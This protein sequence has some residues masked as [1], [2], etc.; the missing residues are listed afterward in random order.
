MSNFSTSDILFKALDGQINID[1]AQGIVECFVA[2]IGNK[3]SVGDVI[4]SGAFTESLKRRKP[5][6]VW[7]HNWN[8][9]IG[10]VL[11]IYEVPA[12]DPRIPMKMKMAG[13]GG[14]YARVQFNLATE[15][16][17]E[18]FGSVA[19]FGQ[20][21]EW[22]IG[23]K[24][25]QAT[26][27]PTMQA[28]VLREV[29]LY[30]VSPVLHGANQLT[31]TLSVKSDENGEKCGPEGM[32]GG[33]RQSRPGSTAIDIPRFNLSPAK[34]QTFPAAN[35]RTDIFASGESGQLGGEARAALEMELSSRSASPLKVVN[36]TENSVV[37]DRTMPDGTRMT[38]RIGYH[39]ESQSGRYMFGKPEKMASQQI[40]PSQMPS[41]PMMVKPGYVTQSYGDSQQPVSMMKSF[42]DQLD[43]A[44]EVLS[45]AGEDETI[46]ESELQKI[47][48]A[49]DYL[50]NLAGGQQKKTALEY[51]VWCK[52][53]YAYEVKSLLDPVLN[54]HRLEAHV[55]DYGVHITSGIN[56]DSLQAL[57]SAH[58]NISSYLDGGGGSKK[59]DGAPNTKDAPKTRIKAL[60][61]KIGPKLGGGLRAAPAGMAFVD[62]TGV[63]DADSDGIV[64]EGKPGLERPIIPRFIVPKNLARKLSAVVEGDAEAIEKQRRSGNGNVSFDEKKLR[65]IIDDIGGDPNLLRSL[66]GTN[67]GGMRSRGEMRPIGS[68]LPF[69]LQTGKPRKRFDETDEEFAK[70][71]RPLAL[72]LRQTKPSKGRQQGMRSRSGDPEIDY[73]LDEQDDRQFRENRLDAPRKKPQKSMRELREE[74]RLKRQRDAAEYDTEAMLDEWADD[75][76]NMEREDRGMRSRG[77]LGPPDSWYEPD[78]DPVEPLEELVGEEWNR[79]DS[80][81]Y[82]EAARDWTR[83]NVDKYKGMTDDEWDSIMDD[84]NASDDP[85]A[86]MHKLFKEYDNSDAFGD[87][88]RSAAQ[89]D[90][91]EGVVGGGGRGFRSRSGDPEID[92]QLDEQDDRQFRDNRLDAPRKKPQKSM[93]ELREEN[94]LKRQREAEN[95]PEYIQYMLDE[96][97]DMQRDM[98]R[99]DRGMRSTSQRKIYSDQVAA[100]RARK[101][102]ED[103]GV[104]PRDLFQGD[105]ESTQDYLDRITP[106]IEKYAPEI[107]DGRS[108][109]EFVSKDNI[110]EVNKLIDNAYSNNDVIR[111]GLD[112]RV[113]N[114]GMGDA[115]ESRLWMDFVDTEVDIADGPA[116]SFLQDSGLVDYIETEGDSDGDWSWSIDV[117]KASPEDKKRFVA[118]A[119]SDAIMSHEGSWGRDGF[120]LRDR[121]RGMRSRRGPTY[122]E[123]FED[124]DQDSD[125]FENLLE[126]TVE[127]MIED[128]E[129]D[130]KDVDWS[131]ILDNEKVMRRAEE[132]WNSDVETHWGD[133]G[134]RQRDDGMRSRL[135]DAVRKQGREISKD[136]KREAKKFAR[137]KGRELLDDAVD[138]IFDRN[139]RDRGMRSRRFRED[140]KPDKKLKP[141][142][143]R[144]GPV[145]ALQNM[146]DEELIKLL[147]SYGE[148]AW[149]PWDRNPQSSSL[150]L[151][152]RPSLSSLVQEL[153]SRGYDVYQSEGREPEYFGDYSAGDKSVYAR[154]RGQEPSTLPNGGMSSGEEEKG[155]QDVIDSQLEDRRR[156]ESKTWKATVPDDYKP[157]DGALETL[158]PAER[159]L[160]ETFKPKSKAQRKQEMLDSFRNQA[161][162]DVDSNKPY[163]TWDWYPT[164]E[165]WDQEYKKKLR[166]YRKAQ[167]KAYAHDL[168]KGNVKPVEERA[169]QQT[170][171]S[172]ENL[173]WDNFKP[174]PLR[175]GPYDGP[176]DVPELLRGF[177]SKITDG[178]RNERDNSVKSKTTIEQRAFDILAQM[179]QRSGQKFGLSDKELQDIFD[180]DQKINPELMKI[181]RSEL[182]RQGFTKD[183]VADVL[184]GRYAGY[185]R[186]QISGPSDDGER[187]FESEMESIANRA[188]LESMD[189][190]SDGLTVDE[191]QDFVSSGRIPQGK[192]SIL[193]RA[194]EVYDNIV[195]DSDKQRTMGL[196]SRTGRNIDAE[197]DT[198]IKKQRDLEKELDDEK[199][200][201]A[202]FRRRQAPL[203]QEFSDLRKEQG[204]ESATRKAPELDATGRPRR[205]MIERDEKGKVKFDSEK[206]LAEQNDKRRLTMSELGFTEDEINTLM[207]ASS[208]GMRSRSGSHENFKN[209]RD[210]YLSKN[211]EGIVN[212]LEELTQRRNELDA[213]SKE[214]MDQYYANGR[215]FNDEE[216]D[217]FDEI[218][219]E[220]DS[221]N[222]EIKGI[223]DWAK[224]AVSEDTQRL[225]GRTGTTKARVA[226]KKM[227]D[228]GDINQEEYDALITDLIDPAFFDDEHWDSVDAIS[229]VSNLRDNFEGSEFDDIDPDYLITEKI[230]DLSSD[231]ADEKVTE[232]LDRL[233]NGGMRSRSGK[234][235]NSEKRKMN[236]KLT[237]DQ[238]RIMQEQKL[239]SKKIPGKKK[240]GPSTNEWGF[241][242]REDFGNSAG[243]AIGYISEIFS[244]DDKNLSS[245]EKY[246]RNHL[247]DNGV[248]IDFYRADREGS[249][250]SDISLRDNAKANMDDKLDALV[251]AISKDKRASDILSNN[252]FLMDDR[253]W[254]SAPSYKNRP[255]RKGPKLGD[256]E[257]GVEARANII[258]LAPG[259]VLPENWDDETSAVGEPMVRI[260]D[261][262]SDGQEDGYVTMVLENMSDGTTETRTFG[263]ND[264]FPN[265]SRPSGSRGG[266]Q[267]GM[268]SRSGGQY[269]TDGSSRIWISDEDGD[270][271]YDAMRDGFQREGDSGSGR[272]YYP[273]RRRRYP[274]S[275]PKQTA[276]KPDDGDQ[277]ISDAS[278]ITGNDL[279]ASIV[280]QYKQRG[281]L[282]DKQW[283]ALRGIVSKNKKPSSSPSAKEGVDKA[284]DIAPSLSNEDKKAIIE[285][286][287]GLSGDFAK[288]VVSQYNSR[289]RLSDKQWAALDKATRKIRGTSN[290]AGMRSRRSYDDESGSRGVREGVAESEHFEGSMWIDQLKGDNVDADV[291][292]LADIYGD[293]RPGYG[294]VGVYRTDDGFGG[295]EYFYGGDDEEFDSVEDAMDFLQNVDDQGNEGI[296]YGDPEFRSLDRVRAAGK[297]GR[298]PLEGM[299]SRSGETSANVEADRRDAADNSAS[300]PI[301]PNRLNELS[302]SD[303]VETRINVANN[304]GAFMET[305]E[306][307]LG[308]D[309]LD[310]RKAADENIQRRFG[311]IANQ[312]GSDRRKPASRQRRE[313]AKKYLAQ[314][315]ERMQKAGMR[316][317]S[318]R[319]EGLEVGEK[320]KPGE[321]IRRNKDRDIEPRRFAA[322]AKRPP[323]DPDDPD[324]VREIADG[325]RSKAGTG[326]GESREIYPSRRMAKSSAVDFVRYDAAKEELVVQYKGGGAYVFGGISADD[327][328]SIEEAESLGKAL[329]DVKRN[330][331]Y[332]VKPNGDVNGVESTTVD[333]LERDLRRIPMSEDEKSVYG[334]AIELLRNGITEDSDLERVQSQVT[335]ISN[336]ANDMWGNDEYAASNFLSEAAEKINKKLN[337]ARGGGGFRSRAGARHQKMEV[338]L[339][340][341]E[342]GL[343][344]D[345]IR[346]ITAKHGGNGMI[347]YGMK[348]YDNLLEELQNQKKSNPGRSLTILS[349]E[350]DNVMTAYDELEK[351]DPSWIKM[352]GADPL[353]MAS[354]SKEGKYTSPNVDMPGEEF[355]GKR[356]NNGA[357]ADITPRMQ[358]QLV[359][360]GRRQPNFR[361]VKGLVEAHK[362]NNGTMTARQWSTLRNMFDRFSEE[363]RSGGVRSRVGSGMRSQTG[364]AVSTSR[365]GKGKGPRTAKD[366]LPENYE[367]LSL[368]EKFDALIS[369]G[370]Y[371][372]STNPN[373]IQIGEYNAAFRRLRD[374]EDQQDRITARR[375]ALA[376]RM[377]RSAEAGPVTRRPEV[378]EQDSP[379][380]ADDAETTPENRAAL[381]KKVRQKQ[382]STIEKVVAKAQDSI[383]GAIID[384]DAE[385]EHGR[386]WDEVMDLVQAEDG[387]DD[388]DLT[389]SK[390]SSIIEA[391]DDYTIGFDGEEMSPAERKSVNNA[392]KLK[393]TLEELYDDIDSDP[394][395]KRGNTSR[396]QAGVSLGGEEDDNPT[397]RFMT[398]EGLRSRSSLVNGYIGSRKNAERQPKA[399]M[400]SRSG[401]EQ[402]G[403]AEIRWE[404]TEFN[405]VEQSLSREI[406]EAQRSG[407]SKT[408]NSLRN[409]TKIMD[410]QKSGDVGGKRTNAGA[411]Y[412]TQSELDDVMDALMHVVDRQTQTDGSRTNMFAQMLD[413]L[414][415]AGMTTFIR[416]T[417]KPVNSRFVEKTNESG[418]TVKIPLNE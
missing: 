11:E 364:S 131:N 368:D 129:L 383:S 69:D 42:D 27:D 307:L 158:T 257:R 19:F 223:T 122:N 301:S 1:S 235:N 36:A 362:K 357:P 226:Y 83:E 236:T 141:A 102:L 345:E 211:S 55:D 46:K 127:I 14:L 215:D 268:R 269:W 71:T 7:G 290:S 113:F 204:A 145:Q 253:A 150:L 265:V 380:R 241:R 413:K 306:R 48:D 74:N 225:V 202:E 237:P 191:F 382:M 194:N 3:D 53:Q 22:S 230:D 91:E 6:V 407:D 263:T 360:W 229:F 315:E 159:R 182:K 52:P 80:D 33:M 245:N 40:V 322:A 400:R 163:D 108:L 352:F 151:R 346:G 43:Q 279:A 169:V 384:G 386:L 310:V 309:D 30:E 358:G 242:S 232:A 284:G 153:D 392:T 335:N 348:K 173:D 4:V 417:A 161:K 200:D 273:S 238:V 318:N 231:F 276:L 217:L 220:L 185:A 292:P 227:L 206:F 195:K 267:Q 193:R 334:N 349:S 418:R 222:D 281:R 314:H 271:A 165:E 300:N 152:D 205:E 256:R 289:G 41:M 117:S 39:R 247:L 248:K 77:I 149:R 16:G 104:D 397:P 277:L 402:D 197:I 166:Q 321:I 408:A 143:G 186:N 47:Q 255:N 411:L 266:R 171:W 139:R 354:V 395:I 148:T 110:S 272:D 92:Y 376:E 336:L 20:E 65:S 367:T 338:N 319:E 72:N 174:K 246:L 172:V 199:I 381:A 294:V 351:V 379:R 59:G 101:V 355:D 388:T 31:A 103:D 356:I 164:F 228:D 412:L 170:G 112:V 45:N 114:D 347:T 157:S 23:Y 160:L 213:K 116:G 126:R 125:H 136:L 138:N 332:S 192:E 261:I 251:N 326:L 57:R 107:F 66:S 387:G 190:L 363:N 86:A 330:A 44:V 60:S 73:Q 154:K 260:A 264:T 259:D 142:Y 216:N 291:I 377:K 339:S 133:V 252:G 214:L 62:I 187:I 99:E 403:R 393:N 88:I 371:D 147:Q 233:K 244:K 119:V 282:T 329:N 278:S 210:A 299:R 124:L 249:V 10:K 316:S 250:G 58:K 372:E 8:D 287:R 105:D 366:A 209:T 373:G 178:L 286:A 168:E 189:I 297:P 389:L 196:R 15:K 89:S 302:G 343:I 337:I 391:L 275:T 29:E 303:D 175:F 396:E 156:S 123:Q 95:D 350:Y 378:M 254:E 394:F 167:R 87:D 311:A 13:V 323:D 212:K 374:A 118:S 324:D 207:G 18:G 54:Y 404:A 298:R 82:Y 342:I 240:D 76:R 93:R 109:D 221:V 181:V 280:Q 176:R 401:T 49:I 295:V 180:G 64:F 340:V 56:E 359:D 288:S 128:D 135:G 344:R 146:S 35:E 12:N 270:G 198:N 2:A 78:D 132:M 98:E 293:D 283:N 96:Q 144:R 296:I 398:G 304:D 111:E 262:R 285:A 353:E 94:R 90:Y 219:N 333:F 34:P 9:P 120:V 37:F 183:D 28:N 274:T 32:Q 50:R 341:D 218:E 137:E 70:R 140:S 188:F 21:Q 331:T 61:G 17:R 234:K 385:D 415:E 224:Y 184:S 369:A 409:L 84:V 365:P 97:A 162:R 399:G 258:D 68:D 410:R 177:R 327:A 405:K 208:S 106:L 313:A 155:T 67:D 134:E 305:V 24:T 203:R 100:D 239:R 308:D 375:E 361:I 75:Q 25:L 179:S 406:S 312:P 85:I 79:G 414:A 38:Y 115:S 51:S 5:R 370:K 63:T 201:L 121:D 243:A 328:D 325:M 416:K 320:F 130:P 317:R 26:F 390:L 81:R